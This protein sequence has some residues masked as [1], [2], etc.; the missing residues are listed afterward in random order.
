MRVPGLRGGLRR[1]LG[2][3][4]YLVLVRDDEGDMEGSSPCTGFAELL[5]EQ[6]LRPY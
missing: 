2:R 3:K 4:R 5:V 6:L 1:G